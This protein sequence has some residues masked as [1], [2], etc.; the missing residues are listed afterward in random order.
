MKHFSIRPATPEDAPGIANVHTLSWI[1]T[2]A[3][4]MPKEYLE[5]ISKEHRLSIW[6]EILQDKNE[7]N[8]TFVLTCKNEVVG[9]LNAGEAR[10]EEYGFE[11]ELYSMYLL[12]KA[13]G[14]G[15]GKQLF[16]AFLDALKEKGINSLYLWVLRE[17]ETAK[18]YESM[19][20]VRSLQHHESFGGKDLIEDLYGWE[21]LT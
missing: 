20:G 6:Q 4:I 19:G 5:S 9:F 14:K 16:Q 11:I 3:N 1:E 18:F 7:F 10:E 12:Q 17:N 2:Y 8:F 15:L 13:Q 21:V